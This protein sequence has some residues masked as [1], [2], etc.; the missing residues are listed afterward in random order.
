MILYIQIS[1]TCSLSRSRSKVN[2]PMGGS[3]LFIAESG[4]LSSNVVVFNGLKSN[5]LHVSLYHAF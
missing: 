5:T 3:E 1:V 2:S 4:S